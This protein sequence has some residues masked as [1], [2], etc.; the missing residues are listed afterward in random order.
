MNHAVIQCDSDGVVLLDKGSLNKTRLNKVITIVLFDDFHIFN[1]F[2][3][4]Q[5]ILKKAVAYFLDENAL[6]MFGEV[7]AKYFVNSSSYNT[8]NE[9]KSNG[10]Y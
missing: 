5:K 7:R 2:M 6:L 10:N 1:T 3:Q 4:L 9:S 8:T